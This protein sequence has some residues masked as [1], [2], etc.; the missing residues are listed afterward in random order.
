M[1]SRGCPTMR[2]KC[3]RTN[4][5]S[6]WNSPTITFQ[7]SAV[8]LSSVPPR[9]AT[10]STISCSVSR[11]F[12]K[13]DGTPGGM[14]AA[15]KSPRTA[16]PRFSIWRAS[17]AARAVPAQW[18]YNARPRSS[19]G[20]SSAKH[21]SAICSNVSDG[22]LH[23]EGDGIQTTALAMSEGNAWA[24]PRNAM[25][26]PPAYGTQR[27]VRRDEPRVGNRKMRDSAGLLSLD[28]RVAWRRTVL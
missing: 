10:N 2:R 18:P 25:A 15:K 7:S 3:S 19:C 5:L 28:S 22:S 17:S 20:D 21:C 6:R 23:S 14:A 26:L 16:C 13:G 12:V 24:S 9:A 1:G 8:P 4:R 27:I 11:G